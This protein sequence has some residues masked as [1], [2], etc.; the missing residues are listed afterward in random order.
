MNR[1]LVSTGLLAG[2][3]AGTGAGLILQQT[4]TAGASNGVYAVVVDDDTS[5]TDPATT[6]PA[7]TDTTDTARPAP[8]ERVREVLQPLVDDGTLTAAQL[9]SVVTAL[10][11]AGPIGGGGPRGHG[12]PGGHGGRGGMGVGLDAAATALGLTVDELR[13]ELEDGSTLASIATEQGV[14]VQTVIDALV[15]EATTRLSERVTAG[16][17]T[18]D[19]ADAKLTNLTERITDMVNNGRPARP[20]RPTDPAATPTA[21]EA[22]VAG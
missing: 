21:D 8:G 2:L 3:V 14:D 20:E 18:Q 16:D 22:T 9:D 10:E 6:D 17:L 7:T 13:T 12:G 4:G 19:E 15:A 5:T 1:K 11:A